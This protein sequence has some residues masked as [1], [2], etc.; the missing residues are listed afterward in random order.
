MEVTHTGLRDGTN[1]DVTI[2]YGTDCWDTDFVSRMFDG[3]GAETTDPVLAVEVER[4]GKLV[5]VRPGG[6]FRIVVRVDS[7]TI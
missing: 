7:S 2:E 3:H 4:N 5:K 6:C 1:R